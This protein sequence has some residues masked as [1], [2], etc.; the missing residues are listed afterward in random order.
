MKWIKNSLLFHIFLLIVAG[1][2]AYGSFYMVRQALSLYRES[3]ANQR[4]IEQLTQRK[5]EL[6]AYLEHLQTP[7]AIEQQ[8]R[9]RLNLKLPGEQVVVVLARKADDMQKQVERAGEGFWKWLFGWLVKMKRG[10]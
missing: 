5:R 3:M 7:G 1:A 9:E 2:V 6:E 8:A 4:K 10:E